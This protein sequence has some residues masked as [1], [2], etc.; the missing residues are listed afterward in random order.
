MNTKQ[1]NQALTFINVKSLSLTLILGSVASLS[2]NAYELID[3]GA[4]VVPKAINNAGEVVGSNNTDQYPA[5]AFRWS[6]GSGLELINGTSANAVNNAGVIAGSTITGAFIMDN[7]Y[8]E[9]SD[10]NA[11]GI[12]QSGEVAGYKVGNNPYRPRSLPYNPAIF[13][14]TKWDVFDIARLY[15]RGTRKGVYADRFILNG[16]NTGGY[17]VGYKYRYGLAGSAAILIDP[18]VVVNDLSDVVYL[19]TPAGGRAADINDNNI[20]TGTTGSNSRTTPITY[21][22]AYIY[23]YDT[24]SLTILPV[25]EGG[26]RSSAN[27]INEINQVVGSSETSMGNHA[28]IWD[29]AN[30]IVDLN[31]MVSATGWVLTSAMAINDNNEIVGTGLLNG[32]AHGFVLSNGTISEPPPAQNRQPEA[33]ADADVTE[34]KA[35]LEVTFTGEA[36]YDPDGTIVMYEWDFGD[37][38]G[39][40][41]MNPLHTYTGPGKYLAS[42]KVT[43]DQ[44]AFNTDQL[45]ITV[46]K[47]RRKK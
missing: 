29:D 3:L 17:T 41:E 6:S 25:L 15:S 27:D 30:G 7:N 34:G 24:S 38:T 8:R 21:S 13:N 14:G 28:F 33:K 2:A 42:L 40:N 1:I 36:S 22:Q 23:N 26:L 16:I 43:D 39:S 5:T 19:P 37:L 9:W 20:I 12:N 32:V 35:A 11:F 44:G 10:Y 31:T 45:E 46:K 47:S 4:N 18:N